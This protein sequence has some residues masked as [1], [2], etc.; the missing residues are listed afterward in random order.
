MYYYSVFFYRFKVIITLTV[1]LKDGFMLN[2]LLR[3]VIVYALL[4][5]AMRI[6]G[7]RQI[8]EMQISELVS[9]LQ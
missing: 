9:A 8:G 5:A 3:T 1:I 7:K 6:G 4:V 2:I